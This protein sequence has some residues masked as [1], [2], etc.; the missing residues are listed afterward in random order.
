M[1]RRRPSSAKVNC[2]PPKRTARG[3]H[4]EPC[5]RSRVGKRSEPTATWLRNLKCF[6]QPSCLN[7][8]GQFGRICCCRIFASASR[9]KTHVQL[10]SSFTIH[11]RAR[12][13]RR[14]SRTV[15]HA[16][17]KFQRRRKQRGG[18]AGRK[19]TPA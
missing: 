6:L 7:Y 14:N 11:A 18:T 19:S 13:I 2:F 3:L 17:D 10:L 12:R 1:T 15:I 16:G 5:E 8:S 9:R 4:S